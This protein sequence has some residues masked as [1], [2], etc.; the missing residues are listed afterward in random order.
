MKKILLA[1]LVVQFSSSLCLAQQAST[2]TGQ[3]APTLPEIRT[4]NGTGRVSL[5]IIGDFTKG[6]KSQLSIGDDY[7]RNLSFSVS[8][9]TL[10]TDKDGK[11]IALGDLKKGNKV[12]VLYAIGKRVNRAQSVKL[13]EQ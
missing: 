4:V 5:V 3:T 13:L 10:I 7:G 8:D 12:A 2:T 9:D 6:I 11:T 1:L